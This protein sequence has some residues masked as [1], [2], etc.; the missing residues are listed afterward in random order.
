M[1]IIG[2]AIGDVFIDKRRHVAL[3]TPPPFRY[4]FL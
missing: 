3:V 2:I 1:N 4:L